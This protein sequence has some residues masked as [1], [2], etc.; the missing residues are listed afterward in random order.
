MSPNVLLGA[1]TQLQ[2]QR[3]AVQRFLFEGITGSPTKPIA[4]GALAPTLRW[5]A[6]PQLHER[7]TTQ[8]QQGGVNLITIVGSLSA[9]PKCAPGIGKI[10]S[11]YGTTRD[12]V[13]PH[14]TDG[15]DITVT[16][17]GTLDQAR[18]SGWGHPNDACKCVAH[19]PGLSISQQGFEYSET[20]DKARERQRDL[21][22]QTRSA[23]RMEATAGDDAT[24]QRAKAKVKQNRPS[25]ET[26]SKRPDESGTQRASSCISQTA[27]ASSLMQQMG[28]PTL[29]LHRRLCQRSEPLGS[30]DSAE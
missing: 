26:I 22:V 2:A 28:G 8:A 7:S 1:Q 15:G 24:A 27:G 21:E 4:T 6:A 10:L 19:L 20:A 12:V 16:I 14:A 30:F 11:T 3:T 5:P 25:S 23:K 9:C 18:A 29:M 13:V 17:Y